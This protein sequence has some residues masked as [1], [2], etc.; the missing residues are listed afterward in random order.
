MTPRARSQTVRRFESRRSPWGARSQNYGED[1][2]GEGSGVWCCG[3]VGAGGA[4]RCARSTPASHVT[5]SAASSRGGARLHAAPPSGCAT[6]A[7]RAGRRACDG[8]HPS[9][10]GICA[11]R[12]A[13][14][15]P[16]AGAGRVGRRA[17]ASPRRR[18]GGASCSAPGVLAPLRIAARPL[19]AAA[20]R[21][22]HPQAKGVW[23]G[24]LSS[25]AAPVAMLQ[26]RVPAVHA[27]QWRRAAERTRGGTAGRAHPPAPSARHARAP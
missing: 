23:R 24:A 25:R 12:R 5:D 20:S 4:S 1:T 27:Q 21:R 19:A 6:A 22:A 2:S 26:R 13:G 11:V 18:A 7:A 17:G 3:G 14:P 16:P 15:P 10:A 8:S 9:A